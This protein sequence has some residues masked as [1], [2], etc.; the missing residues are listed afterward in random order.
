M[1]RLFIFFTIFASSFAL[2]SCIPK[3][4]TGISKVSI[5]VN[6][7]GLDVEAKSVV[8]MYLG[9]EV[10]REKGT[11]KGFF[12]ENNGKTKL[13]EV[14]NYTAKGAYYRFS[15]LP[16]FKNEDSK[17]S[18]LI[19][20]IGQICTTDNVGDMNT[21]LKDV[22]INIDCKTKVN[23]NTKTNLP[24]NQTI[25]FPSGDIYI[26]KP[27]LSFKLG[28]KDYFINS[29]SFIYSTTD[30]DIA[31][32]DKNGKIN[33]KKTGIVNF[34]ISPN[35]EYYDA[36][37]SIIYT[38]EAK[39]SD[40]VVQGLE[41]G[42]SSL[43][44]ISSPF[45]V[46]ATN[47]KTIIRALVYNKN[48]ATS[49]L[50][51][52]KITLMS[53]GKV[54]KV[55]DLNCPHEIRQTEFEKYHYEL[56]DTCYKIL[57]TKEELENL[58][59]DAILKFDF[60][61]NGNTHTFYTTPNISEKKNLKVKLI[62]VENSLGK[63]KVSDMEKIKNRILQVFPFGQVEVV[64]RFGNVNLERQN[65][66]SFENALREIEKIFKEE[67]TTNSGTHYYAFIP[68]NSCSGI[69]GMGY[70][71]LPIAAGIAE[72]LDPSASNTENFG[73]CGIDRAI[74]GTMMHELGH[75]F[76]LSHAPCGI[77]DGTDKFW[78]TSNAWEGV[79]S[80][81]LSKSPLFVQS[82]NDLREPV[83]KSEAN[84]FYYEYDLMGYCQGVRLT[85]HNYKKVAAYLNNEPYYKVASSPKVFDEFSTSRKNL[86][87][88]A[89]YFRILS[90][91][92]LY[93]K[94]L[95]LLEPIR[96]TSNEQNLNFKQNA[97]DYWVELKTKEKTMLYPLT[98]KQLD[99][100]PKMFFELVLPYDDEDIE[101]I[102]FLQGENPLE[103]KIVANNETSEISTRSGNDL[104]LDKNERV[105]LKD[106]KIIWNAK[107]FPWLT[108]VYIDKLGDRTLIASQAV[109]GV[110][111]LPKSLKDGQVE[112]ILSDGI[113]NKSQRFDLKNK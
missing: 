60:T 40:F 96:L 57:D 39:D 44:P 26:Q 16:N 14:E 43:L 73:K 112:V 50:E 106:D 109:G 113:N 81:R 24:K 75:N 21:N 2:N 23:L 47:N 62:L 72:D 46:L 5:F 30:K 61:L 17:K 35:P 11:I 4:S 1:F 78:E 48:S 76:S 101:E 19:N 110:L 90:G 86:S 69:V 31:T 85:K 25:G 92:I 54:N 3:F 6:L 87:K 82:R 94:N 7:T 88:K 104:S 51:S 53:K 49:Q 34:V 9:Y 32:I 68:T 93:A 58:V 66:D 102:K 8:R 59:K 108:C 22:V 64:E 67:V 97:F 74:Y 103:H 80:G 37:Q 29:Q 56:K 107:K 91:E 77:N 55:F 63:A 95:V 84:K 38:L 79:E 33:F 100:S 105:N 71:G 10:A 42:Q 45:E 89:K 15:F 99:H 27:T 12:L 13:A 98:I 41:I 28:T 65:K 111:S 52:A 18:K 83:W 36:D 20:N 70:L